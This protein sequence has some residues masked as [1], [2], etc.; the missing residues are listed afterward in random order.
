M[1]RS[2]TGKFLRNWEGEPKKRVN[3]SLTE[4]AWDTLD[5][6]AKTR[7]LSRSEVIEL[8]ARS[9]KTENDQFVDI[10]ETKKTQQALRES[11]ARFR[12]TAAG[13]F[14][15]IYIFKSIRDETGQIIDFKFVDLNARG[16]QLISL[17]RETV[18]GQNLCEL[19]PINRT[20]GF[21]EKY[22][23]VVETKVPLEEEFP[24]A[25]PGIIASWLRHQVVPLEDGVA[26]ISRDISEQKR[27]EAELRLVNERF[28][29]ATAAVKCLIY[30]WNLEHNRVER[31]QGLADLIGYRPEEAEPTPEWWRERVHPEDLPRLKNLAA[32][33]PANANS[34]TSEYRIRHRDGY[35]RHIW[36]RGL[37]KRNTQGQIVRIVGCTLDITERRQSEERLKRYRLLSEH[38]RDIVLC[39]HSD[40]RIIEAN[41]AAVKAYGYD[42]TE[43]LS[44]KI[45]DLRTPQTHADLPRQFEQASEQGILF[46]TVHRRKD[47]SDFP[48]EVSAQSAE[49]GNEKVV[50]SI[51]R[52]I[53]ERKIA[54]AEREQLLAR[55]R[56]ARA[57][58]EKAQ[59]QLITIFETSPIGIGF[60]D[61]EQ[62]FVAINEALAEI[63]GLSREQHLGHTIPE[64][65][66]VSDPG[67]VELFQTLYTTGNP[68]IS[69]QL[70]VNVPGRDDRRPGYYNVYYLPTASQ[71]GGVEGV[72]VYVVD[73]TER[74]RLEQAQQ[75][76]FE[77]STVLASS[78]DYQTTLEQLAQ[79]TVPKLADWCT[80]HLIENGAIE[81]LA[82]A[83]ID[84]TKLEWA[85]Q[86]KDKY[87][88]DTNAPRGAALTLRTG[89]PDLLPD[90][91][92]ELIVQAARDSEH[93]QILR[94][95]GFKSVMSVPL[96]AQEQ[97]I[98]VIS[99]IGAESGRHYNQTDL[100]IASELARRASLAIE[101]ARLYKTAQENRA[102]AEMANRIKDEFLAVLSHELRTPLN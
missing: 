8:Y 26:I 31:T 6:F 15:A 14:D 45:V 67:L 82:V 69:P 19:V 71:D 17:P 77:A 56:Q 85:S 101:N 54:E 16:E 28:E 13:S 60:L 83:H 49:I 4:T 48:V 51:I 5:E 30:D 91:P 80:I 79:L 3:L 22:K 21:F 62:R 89:E 23:Q 53:S 42:F 32:K 47:G 75:Y 87:P 90:I 65:F 74:V 66:G 18:I 59:Q 52:D 100:A 76:L 24:I 35:Y 58:G 38:S 93:L 64:L 20:A 55:E 36:D 88:L 1:K 41:Q 2:T 94:Q 44:L 37:I 72:L 12:A 84:P 63:N 70:A 34:F 86:L 61:Q 43:L 7:N 68:F 46:E 73:V 92:D 98:G 25:A 50:L 57:E 97:V 102:Q 39:L 9:L 10:T 81:Q 27:I 33:L 78:L 99:F 96:R 40:G 29:L 95:V 11:E